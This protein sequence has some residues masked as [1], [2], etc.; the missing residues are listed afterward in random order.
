KRA[1][2]SFR[3]DLNI[4]QNQEFGKLQRTVYDAIVTLAKQQKYDLILSQGVVYA[5]PRVDV[6]DQVLQRLKAAY[7]PQHSG[8]GNKK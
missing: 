1:Q 6:T 2:D 7:K 4:R 5:G 3:E 8:N